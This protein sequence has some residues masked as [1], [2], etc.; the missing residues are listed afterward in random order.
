MTESPTQHQLR[1]AVEVARI[2]DADGNPA[3]DARNA[4]RYILTQG[5]HRAAS[6]LA[7]ETLLVAAGLLV[8]RDGR[9]YRTDG[10][11]V[12]ANLEAEVAADVVRAR[13]AAVVDEAR[14]T[15]IGAVGEI[16]VAEACRANL[17]ELGR[18]D[19]ARAVQRVSL[20]DDGLGYDVL[21]PTLRGAGRLLEVKTSARHTPG[22]IEFFLSRN[23][24][25]VGQRHPEDWALVAC[26]FVS[27]EA[28]VVGW[29]RASALT[30]Y[31]PTDGMGHW[32][33]ARVQLP[34]VQLV[35]GVPP[36]V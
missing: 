21:A 15:F 14:R 30:T 16:A 8:E 31:L 13:H 20:V 25:T 12:L 28:Q 23:E 6:L 2:I 5:E 7:G 17:V 1:A 35:P 24:Y 3:T 19:L 18:T 32:T 36:A 22:A 27:E 11:A 33:E 4:Y 10:L 29:C 26:A 9:L 34:S